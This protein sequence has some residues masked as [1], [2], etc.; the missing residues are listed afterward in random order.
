[1]IAPA[2]VHE[3]EALLTAG[4]YSQ[5]KIARLTGISRATISAIA[6]G[7]R[8]DYE[9]RQQLRRLEL[10]EPPLGPPARC[11]GCGGLVYMP[12]RLCRVRKLK[13]REQAAIQ[14]YRK[15]NREAALVRIIAAIK[16]GTGQTAA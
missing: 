5:R 2:K 9:L 11:Q 4:L 8:P 15:Q 1:M 12:C 13:T 10:E 3:V 16:T 14:F 6:A 7:N